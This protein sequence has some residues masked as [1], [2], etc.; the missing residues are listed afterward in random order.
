MGPKVD[1]GERLCDVFQHSCLVPSLGVMMKVHDRSIKTLGL[2][3]VSSQLL[4]WNL[5]TRVALNYIQTLSFLVPED[6]AMDW[7]K[8]QFKASFELLSVL[9]KMLLKDNI[10][11]LSK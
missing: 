10:Q 2:W 9:S 3:I 6:H 7:Q 5:W 4:S 1:T 8:Q 11:Q